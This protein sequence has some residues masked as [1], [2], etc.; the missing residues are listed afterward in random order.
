[1][2]TMWENL[3]PTRG[4]RVYLPG[5][6]TALIGGG[7]YQPTGTYVETDTEANA[8]ARAR[9]RPPL[10]PVKPYYEEPG[11]ISD[12]EIAKMAPQPSPVNPDGSEN[13]PYPAETPTLPT[14]PGDWT[15]KIPDPIPDPVLPVTIAPATTTTAPES[16]GTTTPGQTGDTPDGGWSSPITGGGVPAGTTD[17][18]ML[19]DALNR[20]FA[21]Q[22]VQGAL[23][24]FTYAPG[25]E[26]GPAATGGG[27]R[28]LL[29]LV[30]ILAAAGGYY[31]YR[32]RKNAR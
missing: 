13:Y 31:Y 1:M 19:L 11:D 20:L 30:L 15:G 29:W 8:I 16:T 23:V 17:S 2:L 25:M 27:N 3:S 9:L 7:Y 14:P 22:P 26:A 24:P 32:K 10:E 4:T 6:E 18:G 12:R 28:T 21:P 5:E